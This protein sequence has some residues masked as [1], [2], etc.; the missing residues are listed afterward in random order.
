MK[1]ICVTVTLKII[2]ELFS[3]LKWILKVIVALIASVLCLF[4]VE[5]INISGA[6]TCDVH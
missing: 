1:T 5:K 4:Y 6:L 3:G 2:T